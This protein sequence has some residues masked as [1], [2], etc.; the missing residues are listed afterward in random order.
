MTG[1][2]KEYLLKN[3]LIQ[4]GEGVVL[5]ISGGADSV[6][7]LSVLHKLSRAMNLKLTVVH[8]N[9]GIRGEEAVEDSRYVE[10]LCRERQIPFRLFCVDAPATA[11]REK[12]SVEEAGRKLR[13]QLLEQVRLE[14]GADKIAVAHNKNDSAETMLFNLFRGTGIK[15]LSGIRPCR[16][17]IIRPI[18]FL[19]RKEIEEYLETEGL[20]YRTDS[21]N[22]ETDYMRNKIRLK[23]F[24]VIT[25]EINTRAVS[26]ITDACAEI[27]ETEEYLGKITN[28]SYAETVKEKEGMLFIDGAAFQR[29][30]K[31]I[32]KR[33]IRKAIQEMA[34]SL[35]DITRTHIE[36]VLELLDK[37][38]GKK[39]SLPYGVE[40]KRTYDGITVYKEDRVQAAASLE[41]LEI[42]KN[43][44]YTFDGGT[45]TLR[46]LDEGINNDELGGNHYT[47]HF[48][49]D[50]IK[51]NLTIRTRRQGDYIT[52]SPGCK[53][54]KL[55]TYF[56]DCKIPREY[57]DETL[58]LAEENHILWIIG[59][60]RISEYYKLSENTRN[61]LEVSYIGGH[62]ER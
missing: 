55:K 48:D 35:K 12:L 62:D 61:I 6:C 2:V 27:A 60:E 10:G 18:L 5:G 8:V 13:Y 16:N 1:R 57:R 17:H 39:I 32:R 20:P 47:K 31:V 53:K 45:V 52:I 34:E 51:G 49:Y 41:P 38:V 26:H 11:A 54:K 59:Q 40:V 28:N 23:L 7:L 22:L 58:L 33:I 14:T 42:E 4:N 29:L 24:P 37:N 9:H 36:D 3:R 43:G 46:L 15:G 44:S 56:I 19:E 30:E 21:T 25:G 50:R